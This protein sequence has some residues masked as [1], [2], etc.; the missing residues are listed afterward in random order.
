[1][2]GMY[3]LEF[4][5]QLERRPQRRQVVMVTAY[6][7]VA[8]AVEAMRHGAFDYIE[9]PFAADRLEQLVDRAIAARPPARP[10]ANRACRRR[11][12]GPADD[13]RL[14]CGDAGPARPDCSRSRRTPETML[15]T[16]ESGTG[17]EL[18]A[19]AVHA[20]SDARGSPLVSLNCPVLSA[21][22]ME[23][24][25]FGHER[26]AFTG[27]D[28]RAPA[29]SNWPTAARSCSTKSPRSSWRCKPSCC[30]CCKN[31]PSSASARATTRQV[32]VRV[33]ATT[34]RNLRQEV[35]AGRF[36]EDLFFRLAVM[37]LV[38]PPLRER[39]EDM[40]ELAESFPMLRGGPPASRALPRSEPARAAICCSATTGRAMCASWKT[41]SRGPA[42]STW[43]MPISADESSCLADRRAAALRLPQAMAESSAR[44]AVEAGLNLGDMERK[45]IEATLER[46]N[47][48]RAKTA[49]ALGSEFARFRE[50]SKPMAM[51]RGPK[52]WRRLD[53][54]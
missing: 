3:G 5:R 31:E 21:H 20:A 24:E 49:Q 46:F 39:R 40:P 41:S 33:L 22:L 45:L 48:H 37:P 26:G 2:P 30:A 13:D 1:M 53:K 42:C 47:G 19:R 11:P 29:A 35:A 36:R 25:L 7:T 43:A 4:I 27:A 9:K 12:I 17:K 38:V 50:N 16:G 34:N 54:G 32:D 15:I 51:R 10:P 28:A 6:A 52:P 14:Q 18:V 23:S 8:S 44:P